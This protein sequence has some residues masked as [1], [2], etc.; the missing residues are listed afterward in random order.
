MAINTNGRGIEYYERNKDE[1]EANQKWLSANLKWALTDGYKLVSFDNLALEQLHIKDRLDPAVWER[2]YMGDEGT[3]S[4]YID[5]VNEQFAVSSLETQMFPLR[6][7]IREMF[8]VVQEV[9]KNGLS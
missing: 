4:I 3:S 8:A 6:D 9:R 2:Y 1:I 7:D 5:L